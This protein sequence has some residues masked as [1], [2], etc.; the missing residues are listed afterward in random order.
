MARALGYARSTGC[1]VQHR[2]PSTQSVRVRPIRIGTGWGWCAPHAHRQQR[3]TRGV[4]ASH[5]KL[6]TCTFLGWCFGTSHPRERSSSAP[7][8]GL[9]GRRR[10]WW[11][12]CDCKGHPGL[13]FLLI[14]VDRTG[15]ARSCPALR[16]GKHKY[17][18]HGWPRTL[19]ICACDRASCP[20]AG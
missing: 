4:E 8:P 12:R 16:F 7:R 11:R 13:S 5:L 19:R 20:R 6:K 10:G 15:S 1:D 14:D 3:K 17:G 2:P 18:F 9:A